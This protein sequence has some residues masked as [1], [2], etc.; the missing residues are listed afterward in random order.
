M[1]IWQSFSGILEVELTSAELTD[2]LTAVNNR[3]IAIRDLHWV[4][5]LTCV[6][7]IKRSSYRQLQSCVRKNGG[8]LRVRKRQ[9]LYETGSRLLRRPVLIFGFGILLALSAYLPGR[10][11]FVRVEGNHRV[12]SRQILEAA[13][14]QG[15]TFGATRRKLRSEQIKNGILSEIPQLQW[16]GVNTAGCV[17]TVSVREGSPREEEKNI[18]QV[19]RIVAAKDGFILSG[20]VEQGTGLFQPGQTVQGGQTL[21]SGYVACD[22]CIRAVRAEGEIRAQTRREIT[23]ITDGTYLQRTCEK[24][25]KRKISLLIRKKRINLWKDSG[26]SDTTCGRMYEE[27]Y[28]TLPGGFPLPVALCVD[29]YRFLDTVESESEPEQ[30]RDCLKAFARNCVR[31][32]MIAGSIQ[33]CDEVF[34]SGDGIYRLRGAYLCEEMIGREQPEQI[35]E[36]NG[37]ND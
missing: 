25:V 24:G 28:I 6:F 30:I 15:V 33:S 12:P 27:Y 18:P 5:D 7:R 14:A 35:G 4:D 32:Q 10:V 19:S 29:E 20:T 21:I 1:N 11:L 17:A 37:K 3:E 9:G 26:I 16:A 31:Q 23:A 8:C 22:Y 13:E 2:A 36:G 34:E